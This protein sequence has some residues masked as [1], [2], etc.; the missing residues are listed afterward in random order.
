MQQRQAAKTGNVNL[1]SI[2]KPETQSADNINGYLVMTGKA[3]DRNF[4]DLTSIMKEHWQSAR[5]DEIPRISDYLNLMSSRRIQGVTGNGHGLAMQAAGACHSKGSAL[6][7]N[8]TGLPAI[9]RLKNWVAQWNEEPKALK[10]WVEQLSQIQEKMQA[11]SAHALLIGE[12]HRLPTLE[13]QLIENG[14]SFGEEARSDSQ[15]IEGFTQKN[16]VWSAETQVNFC[17]AAYKT[18][19]AAHED[20]APLTVL[21]GVLRN[22]FLHTKIREQGGAYGGGASHDNSNGVFRFYSYRDPRIEE[23]LQDFTGS[24]EWLKSGRFSAEQVEEAVLGVVGS[25]DK[26]GSPAGEVKGAYQNQLFDRTDEFRKQYRERILGVSKD[27]LVALA[28]KYFDE[29]KKSEA[30]VTDASHAER[31]ESKGFTW[32]KI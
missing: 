32:H 12:G 18:V 11:Q 2:Y 30:V 6:V 24:V 20:S 31:L 13:Q 1:Y 27:K 15:E 10:A 14:L 26:P 19:P 23:T 28:D 25:L 3:L 17:S 7:Y 29:S 22:N 16:L 9:S 4:A 8:A 5:F 21:S